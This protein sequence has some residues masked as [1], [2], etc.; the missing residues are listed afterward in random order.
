MAEALTTYS[1]TC[2]SRLKPEQRDGV[3]QALS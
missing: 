3:M 1:T 2:S